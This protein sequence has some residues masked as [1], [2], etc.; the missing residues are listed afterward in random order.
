MKIL[1]YGTTKK[2]AGRDWS[3]PNKPIKA[4]DATITTKIS[5]QLDGV[6]TIP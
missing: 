5:E 6:E 4:L 1:L 2:V 3:D